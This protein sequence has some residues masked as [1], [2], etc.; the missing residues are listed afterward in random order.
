[1]RGTIRL[2]ENRCKGCTRCTLVCPKE[3]IQMSDHFTPRG[4]HPAQLVDPTGV[5][6]G[7]LLCA[8]VCPEAGITI[9]CEAARRPGAARP[10]PALPATHAARSNPTPSAPSPSG[11]ATAVR[12]VSTRFFGGDCAPGHQRDGGPAPGRDR[13]AARPG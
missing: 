12:L 7:C 3:L 6:T 8:T 5:C 4:Y 9:Y 11:G 1:M 13:P 10:C 2:D